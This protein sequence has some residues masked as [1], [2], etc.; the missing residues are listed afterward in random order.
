MKKDSPDGQNPLA[1][2]DAGRS[3]AFESY[4]RGRDRFVLGLAE[5]YVKA[6]EKSMCGLFVWR[7]GF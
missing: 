3:R 2:V 4:L 1:L 5:G 7:V 6:L